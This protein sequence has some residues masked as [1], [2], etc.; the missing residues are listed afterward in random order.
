VA[1][2]ENRDWYAYIDHLRIA[3]ARD[4]IVSRLDKIRLLER[5]PYLHPE[6]T[7]SLDKAPV[8]FVA[9][10]RGHFLHDSGNDK[11]KVTEYEPALSDSERFSKT[12]T[13]LLAVP[14]SEVKAKLD[15]EKKRKCRKKRARKSRNA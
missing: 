6:K 4:S 7:V 3:S 5:N 15:A 1:L 8:Q 14:H 9:L 12:L 11:V 2:P 13:R 10:H